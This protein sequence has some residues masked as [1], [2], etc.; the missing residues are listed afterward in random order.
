MAVKYH[1][2]FIFGVGRPPWR[3]PARVLEV[4]VEPLDDLTV[5]V[6]PVDD[7]MVEVE[8]LEP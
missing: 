1:R 6:E 3:Y 4:E 7:L 5:E 8:V 2:G